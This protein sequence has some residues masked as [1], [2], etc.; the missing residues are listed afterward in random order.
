MKKI[1]L[2]LEA[3][4]VVSFTTDDEPGAPRGTVRAHVPPD[5]YFT[6]GGASCYG[7]CMTIEYA[8]CQEAGPTVGPSCDYY[9][10]AWTAGCYPLTEAPGC[11]PPAETEYC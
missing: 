5:S 8:T 6:L 1:R 9:C 3:L 7:D 2:D 11:V 10:L 4:D